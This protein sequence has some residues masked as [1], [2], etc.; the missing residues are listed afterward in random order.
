VN[1]TVRYF[2]VI[3][4]RIAIWIVAR[5]IDLQRG[6]PK[7]VTLSEQIAQRLRH[8]VAVTLRRD[9]DVG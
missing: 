5:M 2:A 6:V 8:L 4:Q 3:E 9:E 7:V 1:S